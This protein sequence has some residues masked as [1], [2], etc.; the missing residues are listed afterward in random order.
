MRSR[1]RTEAGRVCGVYHDRDL[2]AALNIVAVRYKDK[3]NARVPSVSLPQLGAVGVEAGIPGFSRGECQGSRQSRGNQ[4]LQG[5]STSTGRRYSRKHD[6]SDTEHH[7]AQCEGARQRLFARFREEA[8]R[9]KA[10]SDD[11]SAAGNRRAAGPACRFGGAGGV[12]P[13]T[14]LRLGGGLPCDAGGD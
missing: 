6:L 1:W 7:D 8:R 13:V 3:L 9:Q 2:N 5:R 10:E 14:G 4:V 12:D 11:E